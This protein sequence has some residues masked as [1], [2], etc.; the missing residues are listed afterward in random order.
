MAAQRTEGRSSLAAT[1]LGGAPP[2]GAN[3]PSVEE[4]RALQRKLAEVNGSPMPG[5][6]LGHTRVQSTSSVSTM[7]SDCEESAMRSVPGLRHVVSSGS[8]SSMVSE[9]HEESPEEGLSSGA[10]IRPV[11]EE[12][13]VPIVDPDEIDEEL[14]KAAQF[15]GAGAPRGAAE[16]P[17]PTTMM[18]RNIPNRYT[19]KELIRELEALGF[20]G[21][22]DFLYVPID[23]ITLCNVGYAFVNFVDSSWA[24]RCVETFD[25]YQFK[26]YRKVRGKIATVS[27]AH[28]QGLEANLRHY[29]NSA[30]NANARA[31][32]RA[33]VVLPVVGAGRFS[34]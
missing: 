18:I 1:S 4:L 31:R 32:G 15:G 9:I 30:V 12:E 10:D 3:A 19:Q 6:L 21:S 23:K 33:P 13:E 20:T 11:L 29:E 17:A 25:N 22:F 28:I 27:V 2:S 5:K 8:V 16:E 14:R 34:G 7:V 26:K 24:R